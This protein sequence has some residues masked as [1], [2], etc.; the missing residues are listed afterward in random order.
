MVGGREGGKKEERG[1]QIAKKMT[2]TSSSTQ[3]GK[4]E[5]GREGGR[6][7]KALRERLREAE[8]VV[9]EVKLAYWQQREV[10]GRAMEVGKEGGRERRERGREECMWCV[11][12]SAFLGLLNCLCALSCPPSL[13][14]SP[15]PLFSH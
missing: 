13:P 10:L 5:G 11:C 3:T 4:E 1:T 9:E 6:E 12:S 7:V 14:P 15:P 8:G 2:T